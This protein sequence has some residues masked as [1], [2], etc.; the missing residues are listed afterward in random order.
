[1]PKLRDL[2]VV[3][4]PAMKTQL[5]SLFCRKICKYHGFD[6]DHDEICEYIV[7]PQFLLIKSEEIRD[8]SGNQKLLHQKEKEIKQIKRDL[9]DI[10]AENEARK[11]PRN[12]PLENPQLDITGGGAIA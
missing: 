4:C 1:M 8:F 2:A 6:R 9:S 3:Q 11:R 7:N 12:R 10:K 5:F